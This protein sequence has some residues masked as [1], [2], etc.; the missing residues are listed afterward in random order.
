MFRKWCPL[1]VATA[2]L[3]L[4]NDTVCKPDAPC[5][6]EDGVVSIASGTPGAIAP[7]T[8]T[9]IYGTRLSYSEKGL[10]PADAAGGVLPIV[11]PGTGVHVF[12]GGYPAHLF[13][14][15][16]TQVNFLVPS[17]LRP[18]TVDVQ[19]VRDGVAGPAIP[20]KLR[21]AAPALFMLDP[22]FVIA[23]HLDFS[24]VT[25]DAPARPSDWVV[26]WA[27]GLGESNPPADYGVI[28]TKAAWI[29][30]QSE[31]RLLLNGTAVPPERITYVGLAPLC[32]GLYQINLLLPPDAGPDPEVRIAVGTEFSPAGTRLHLR[33]PGS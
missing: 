33:P 7:N 32:A 26:L 28:P 21:D 2:A 10:V 14:V 15:S 17:N 19:V 22:L 13:Y 25:A 23:S 12:V 5:Y 8:L 16:A 9:S 4:A 6:G 1:A 30:R 24:L 29:V 11:L 27:T 31:F 18:A 20:L 3:C